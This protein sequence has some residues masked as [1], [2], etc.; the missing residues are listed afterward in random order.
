MAAH[1]SL[2]FATVLYFRTPFSEVTARKS[3]ELRHMFKNRRPNFGQFPP[4][5]WDPKLSIF[6]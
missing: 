2:C 3:T 6:E 1:T 4:K 5:T